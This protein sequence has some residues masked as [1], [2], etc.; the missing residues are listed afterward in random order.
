MKPL[1]IILLVIGIIILICILSSLCVYIV[2]GTFQTQNKVIT[3]P[4]QI[5]EGD[6]S[7]NSSQNID[8]SQFNFSNIKGGSLKSI[9]D[10]NIKVVKAERIQILS[11]E[12]LNKTLD[13][14]KN[15]NW[16]GVK[17][18]PLPVTLSDYTQSDLDGWVNT[19]KEKDDNLVIPDD[20]SRVYLGNTAISEITDEVFKAR[21][22]YLSFLKSKG[23]NQK[24]IDE[25][26]NHTFP[27]SKDRFTY[28]AKNDPNAGLT[29]VSPYN[30]NDREAKYEL[31]AVDVYLPSLLLK[32]SLIIGDEPSDISE[33]VPYF[34]RLRNMAVRMTTYHELTHVLQRAVNYTNTVEGFKYP[35][36]YIQ[37]VKTSPEYNW[38]GDVVKD[39]YNRSIAEESQADGIAFVVLTSMYDMSN[40]QKEQVWDHFF[41]RLENGAR[42]Y[43]TFM[44][45][46][47]TNYPKYN[48]WDFPQK[49][50]DDVIYKDNAS[51]S[52]PGKTLVKLCDAV[53]V[54]AYGGYLNPMTPDKS[55]LLWTFLKEL[56]RD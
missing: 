20:I 2:L 21:E 23:V 51:I 25:I 54:A 56:H 17:D 45:K 14:A 33:V 4:T 10:S 18:S 44:N 49:I 11:L 15:K 48:A 40:V 32:K 19:S 46:F 28:V 13:L 42:Q 1:K 53:N 9:N 52:E 8:S 3:N 39:I 34:T 41:G 31:Q 12:L 27:N 37:S 38:G 6:S 47:E 5:F 30:G 24:Y 26:E 29:G 22:E 43:E 55:E 36:V 50:L 35:T 7:T 16:G